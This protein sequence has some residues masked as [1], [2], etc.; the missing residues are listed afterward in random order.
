MNLLITGGLLAFAIVAILVAV[1]LGISDQRDQQAHTNGTMPAHPTEAA[2]VA[3]ATL[4]A[5][6]ATPLPTPE[7]P[8]QVNRPLR[9]TV[10]L[11]QELTLS[12][13]KPMQVSQPL[14]NQEELPRYALNGQMRELAEELRSLHQ[15]AWDLEQRLLGLTETLDRVGR[16]D[17]APGR[18]LSVDEEVTQEHFPAEAM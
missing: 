2:P 5:P 14:A 16:T 3:T 9:R 4:A 6:A 15:Q 13:E 11:S 1:L 10:P 18:R 17:R 7:L 12:R 8:D